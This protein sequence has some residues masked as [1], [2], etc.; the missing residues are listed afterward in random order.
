MGKSELIR[1]KK[2]SSKCIRVGF[3]FFFTNFSL[4]GYFTGIWLFHWDLG[5]SS[6]SPGVTLRN[7]IKNR[8]AAAA[9]TSNTINIA[10]QLYN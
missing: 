6:G 2:K 8:A 10:R 4:F 5:L 9:K 7:T 1:Y 3:F